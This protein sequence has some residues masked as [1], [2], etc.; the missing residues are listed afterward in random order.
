[1][2]T[3]KDDEIYCSLI[4]PE[5]Y[6]NTALILANYI[7]VKQTDLSKSF[8]ETQENH[9]YWKKYYEDINLMF[10]PLLFTIKH[11]VE[12]YCKSFLNLFWKVDQEH[13][14]KLLFCKFKCLCLELYNGWK[15]EINI[16]YFDEIEEIIKILSNNDKN[17]IKNRYPNNLEYY[18]P[19]KKS[20][21]FFSKPD[22][23]KRETPIYTWWNLYEC[24]EKHKE[25]II[26][27]WDFFEEI[28][29]KP[30]FEQKIKEKIKH[31]L[32]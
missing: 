10:N 4:L 27:L 15:I 14:I 26:T 32:S 21:K 11:W 8:N 7:Y 2:I 19:K 30:Y 3:F 16:S 18:I 22:D 1:M 6:L 17:N 9:F 20:K 12:L 24:I 28:W 5:T 13:D 25:T 31:P 23:Y 29:K